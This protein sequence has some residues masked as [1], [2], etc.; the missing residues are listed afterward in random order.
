MGCAVYYQQI[1]EVDRALSTMDRFGI[2][3]EDPGYQTL[4]AKRGELMAQVGQKQ[5]RSSDWLF[6][7]A[8]ESPGTIRLGHDIET[9]WFAEARVKPGAPPIY[10]RLTDEEAMAILKR[11]MSPQLHDRLFTPDIYQGE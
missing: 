1:H 4:S 3:T 2:S 8:F 10:H 7:S 5:P 11:E 9:G 6:I